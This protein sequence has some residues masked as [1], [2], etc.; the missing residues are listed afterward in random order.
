MTNLQMM[1]RRS[2]GSSTNKQPNLALR[3]TKWL[4]CKTKTHHT[5]IHLTMKSMQKCHST[6]ATSRNFPLTALLMQPTAA[7]WEGVWMVQYTVQ[8]GPQ[9]REACQKLDGC[10][11][12]QAKT[13]LGY[14]LPAKYII[15]TVG[16]QI[17][18]VEDLESC[19]RSCLA[20]MLK[21]NLQTLT[22]PC[23]AT[24]IYGFPPSV[25]VQVALC[26]VRRFL[27]ELN[28]KK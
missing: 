7:C 13:T 10:S 6:K 22:V 25:A 28:K 26:A 1:V 11:T 17:K 16:P 27:D 14:K 24:A 8:R 9:L 21:N 2:R 5:S 19:Y 18:N 15:H 4:L 23:I 12:G 3:L 20:E